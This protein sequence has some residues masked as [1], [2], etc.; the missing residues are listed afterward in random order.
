MALKIL[1]ISDL[2]GNSEFEIPKDVE[3]ILVAGDIMP[4][5]PG[6]QA[7]EVLE[8]KK[9]IEHLKDSGKPV[10]LVSG[11]VDYPE[12]IERMCEDSNITFV[13]YGKVEFQDYKIIAFSYGLSY[14]EIKSFS[15]ELFD[16]NDSKTIL[17]THAPPLDTSTDR[18]LTGEHVGELAYREIIE[19]HQPILHVCGHI[20]EAQGKDK[21]GKATVVNCGYGKEGQAALIELNDKTLKVRF[22]K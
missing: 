4:Y 3:L 19:E 2:H 1:A 20:H 13:P 12:E 6:Y 22:V 7:E 5:A 8:G 11:N 16:E 9:V 18:V 15:K 21:I 10:I 14:E 17:L